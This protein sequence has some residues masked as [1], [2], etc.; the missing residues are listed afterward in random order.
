MPKPSSLKIGVSG[1][2]GIVGESLSPQLVT[3]FAAAFGCHTGRGP[4]LVGT[5]SRP[6]R[7]MVKRGV[8]AGL[9][10][11]G[12]QPIDLGVLPVPALQH[13]IRQVK[14]LGGI[15][16]TASHNPVEWNALKFFAE[17]GIL[18]RP[19]Q[20]AELTDLYHQGVFPRVPANEIA[21]LLY[22]DTAILKHCESVLS[23]VDVEA[24]RAKHF[25]VVCDC[26]NGAASIATPMFLK[27][28]GCDVVA[29]N[30]NIDLPFPHNPEPVPENLGQICDAVKKYGGEVG[31]VQDADAD[32]LALVN[33]FGNPVG[34]EYTL[35][36]GILHIAG[37]SKNPVVVNI[38]SSRL[39]EDAAALCGV[40]MVYAKVG[41]VNVVQ[42][43]LELGAIV[44]GEGNGG[45][46]VPA[47]NPC[48]DSFV[49]MALM[50]EALAMSGLSMSEYANKLPHYALAR[51]K[52]GIPA[53]LIQPA[54]AKLQ[55]HYAGQTMNFIDGLKILWPDAWLQ[56]RGS[57]TEPIMRV[58]AE[59]PT[60]QRADE[61]ADGGLRVI[62]EMQ[63]G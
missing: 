6:S 9:L 4:I 34:E 60:Q 25:R 55:E 63:N 15:C 5:D 32:R 7:E 52:I 41:E 50:L 40:E 43:M 8:I 2:R 48:R 44:G 57:N 23:H 38:S 62:A 36:L 30:D 59:A 54:L 45:L 3:T 22:D 11:V 31:F 14:A 39:S 12:C 37:R 58:I 13:H 16:V 1:V 19:N 35:A 28:L 21:E 24:I 53:R 27:M 61:L 33:E 29:I 51:R 47:I 18:L 26:C 10:S 42:K 56:A 17:D 20:A 46:I 49:G